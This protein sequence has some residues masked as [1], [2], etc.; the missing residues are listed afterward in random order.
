MPASV[1]VRCTAAYW[2][3][4]SK[5]QRKI[6]LDGRESRDGLDL[7]ACRTAQQQFDIDLGKID[8]LP[9]L[10]RLRPGRMQLSENRQMSDARESSRMVV[11]RNV[12]RRH[13]QWRVKSLQ[14]LLD[15]AF[16]RKEIEVSRCLMNTQRLQAAACPSTSVR[17]SPPFQ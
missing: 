14:D 17:R 2:V 13:A 9:E 3:P 12:V 7:R 8:L 10:V 1:I 6:P 11:L 4:L 16:E 5:E 15:V